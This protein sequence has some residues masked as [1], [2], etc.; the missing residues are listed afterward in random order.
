[1]ALVQVLWERVA[2]DLAA[3]LTQSKQTDRQISHESRVDYFAV[4]RMRRGGLKRRTKNAMRLCSYF[5]ISANTPA[6][7]SGNYEA[8]VSELKASWDGSEAHAQLL[9]ELIR[10]TRNFKVSQA[11]SDT[12]ASMPRGPAGGTRK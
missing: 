4:R 8:I 9:L 11:K 5:A 7:R 1:M 12:I 3:K 2:R 6:T 10:T